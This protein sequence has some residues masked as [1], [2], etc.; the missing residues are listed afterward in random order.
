[1]NP[2]F[3]PCSAEKS[4]PYFALKSLIGFK[5]TS[6]NV[7]SIAVSCLTVNN[8]LAIVERN[9]DIGTLSSNLSIEANAGVEGLA[10]LW[11]LLSCAI[12]SF[13]GED[14]SR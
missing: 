10:G 4:S 1:M 11:V 9:R 8:L 12:S 5:S 13:L 7:V 3:T 14:S 6:L 2:S